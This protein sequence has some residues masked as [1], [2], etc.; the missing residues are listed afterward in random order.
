MLSGKKLSFFAQNKKNQ[1]FLYKFANLEAYPIWEGVI[2][3]KL[4]GGNFQLIVQTNMITL[5]KLIKVSQRDSGD[6]I[7]K[8]GLLGRG[9]E[10]D[11]AVNSTKCKKYRKFRIAILLIY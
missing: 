3:T 7:I 2:S 4:G 10:E 9:G 1:I 6:N 5:T 8:N 11:F